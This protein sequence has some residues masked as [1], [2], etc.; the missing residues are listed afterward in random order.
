MKHRIIHEAAVHWDALHEQT[1][2]RPLYPNEHVVRFLMANRPDGSGAQAKPRVLDLGVG[3]GRHL[4]LVA[5][6]GFEPYGVDIS[7]TGLQ[8][9]R[10]WVVQ[11]GVR[12]HLVK[13]SMLALPFCDGAFDLVVSFGVL[14]Y[15]TRGEMLRAIGELHRAI[16]RGGKAFVVLR[17]TDDYRFA[18]GDQ[19]E[20][21]TF[22]LNIFETNEYGTVQHFLAEVNVPAYFRGF[23]QVVFEKTETTFGARRNVNS[24][25]LITLEK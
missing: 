15:G 22:Q 23:S 4:N 17:T 5:E 2:F 3:G 12:P 24:D 6:L 9:A 16:R 1:R 8:R 19:I 13:A 18:R 25:W 21:Q 14:Y 10:D 11:S 7:L 20:A